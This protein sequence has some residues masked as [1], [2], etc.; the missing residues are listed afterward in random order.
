MARRATHFKAAKEN[1]GVVI[2]S[3]GYEF[4]PFG[5]ET[6][7]HPAAV[8]NLKRA[9]DLL[10]YDI[11][12]LAPADAAVFSHAGL[13]AGPTW[14]GPFAEPR[15]V[16]R[17]APGGRLAFVLFPDSGQPDPALEEDTAR[18]A[19]ALRGE[20][21]H[22]LI[23]GVSTWGGNRENDFIERH[24]EAYDIIMG[25]GPGPGYGGLFMRDNALLWV[26][27][28]TKGRSVNSVTIPEL[29]GPGQKIVWEPQGNVFTE[30]E[31]LD[32]G[33]ATDPEIDAIFNP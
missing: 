25:S 6:D 22:N 1:A 30:A 14:S 29:P 33:V 19:A 24:G 15:L 23:I 20:G 32:G 3:G 16:E 26:R 27:A 8:G 5:L 18:F 4:S 28:F 11:A 10:G 17:D 9:Y 13:D 21:R 12:L 2:V 31:S 7:R